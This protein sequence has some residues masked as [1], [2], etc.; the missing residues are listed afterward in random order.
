ML[1]IGKDLRGSGTEG[2]L[3]V[4]FSAVAPGDIDLEEPVYIFFEGTPVPFFF[5]SFNQKGNS[6]AVVSL[7]GVRNLRDAEE[8]R[9]CELYADYFEDDE[10]PDFTGWTLED[11]EGA[12]VGTVAGIE[13]IPGNPCLIVETENG[14]ALVPLAEELVLSV[15]EKSETLRMSVPEGLLDY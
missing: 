2:E 13:P 11:A 1:K 10:G 12:K 5:G 7:T 8:L 3:L 14:Q 9:G 15:D 6:K 4:S